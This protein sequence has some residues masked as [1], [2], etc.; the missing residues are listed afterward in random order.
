MAQ[1]VQGMILTP[2]AYFVIKALI[3]EIKKMGGY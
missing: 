2:I 1:I 3:S